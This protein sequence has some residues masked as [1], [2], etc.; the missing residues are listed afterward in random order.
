MA[1]RVVLQSDQAEL[2]HQDLCGDLRECS[3]HPGLDGSN[4][5]PHPS[6]PE[7]TLDVRLGSV[8]SARDAALQPVRLSR[9][10]VV[11]Q[12]SIQSTA[13]PSTH[14][15]L[16][17]FGQ[18]LRGSISL[19]R[20]NDSYAHGTQRSLNLIWTAVGTDTLVCAGARQA[21][22]SWALGACKHPSAP[23]NDTS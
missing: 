2:A 9:S 7:V 14:S 16:A 17:Q 18:H 11:D 15:T 3:S 1:D 23:A 6:V 10:V 22:D 8:E 20:Q 19:S 12:R 5:H 21:F 13:T 4:R